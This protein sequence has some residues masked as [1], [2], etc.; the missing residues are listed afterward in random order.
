MKQLIET[1]HQVATF[2]LSLSLRKYGSRRQMNHS[3][4]L[5]LHLFWF[6][7]FMILQCKWMKCAVLILPSLWVMSLGRIMNLHH[8]SRETLRRSH[9]IIANPR[10]SLDNEIRFTSLFKV[11]S[12]LRF[13]SV[14]WSI[15]DSM[16]PNSRAQARLRF[17]SSEFKD[18][19]PVELN[20]DF[21]HF[22]MFHCERA[23][24]DRSLW[25]STGSCS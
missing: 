10:S 3:R 15:C 22:L 2:F 19:F 16:K 24:S 14:C 25:P 6:L 7:C 8:S 9:N 18:C 20:I 4:L 17:D 5:C 11:F 21:L 13:S 12:F 23:T 1:A